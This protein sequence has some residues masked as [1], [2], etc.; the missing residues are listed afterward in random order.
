MDVSSCFGDVV[1]FRWE[2]DSGH[3]WETQCDCFQYDLPTDTNGRFEYT[4]KLANE[5]KYPQPKNGWT[6]GLVGLFTGLSLVQGGKTFGAAV[7]AIHQ[8]FRSNMYFCAKTV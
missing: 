5:L 2:R 8:A 1:F 3:T 6:F 7:V 4:E